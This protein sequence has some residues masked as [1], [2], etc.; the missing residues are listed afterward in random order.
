MD[1]L[2]A[3]CMGLGL[4]ASCGFRVFAPL[5][6]ACLSAKMGVIHLSES[7][8]WIASTP[9]LCAFAAATAI[10]LAAYWLPSI[11]HALDAIAAP[12]ALAAGTVLAA[13]QFGDFNP[14]LIWTA[15]AVGG[16]GAA[17]LSQTLNVA[18][19]GVAT[20]TTG[21]IF[22]PIVSAVQSGISVVLSILS[23]VVPIFAAILV[24]TIVGLAIW[25]FVAARARRVPV[26]EA[27]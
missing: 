21:G 24:L 7:M 9:A 26:P 3:V 16:G 8:L 25:W 19:R 10:E 6:I 5:L 1:A 20:V 23:I 11:D 2:L 12:C 18:T 27:V 22:N 15:A 17:G 13:S 14:A 4:A